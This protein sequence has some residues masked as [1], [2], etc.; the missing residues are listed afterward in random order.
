MRPRLR[1]SSLDDAF[2]LRGTLRA[3]KGAGEVSRR[4]WDRSIFRDFM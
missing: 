2:L 1:L 3:C 4:D